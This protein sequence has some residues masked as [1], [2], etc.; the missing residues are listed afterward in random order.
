MI[1]RDDDGDAWLLISQVDHAM[2]AADLAAVW[3]NAEVA[4]LPLAD[5]LVPAIRDHDEGWRIWEEAPSVTQEGLPRQF[6]EMSSDAAEQIWTRSIETCGTGYGSFADALRRL[7][8]EGGEVAPDDASV[9]EAVL[10]Y[11]KTISTDR[12]AAQIV[13]EGELTADAVVASL[14]R[15]ERKNVIRRLPVVLGGPAYE[16]VVPSSGQSPLGGIWVSKHFCALAEGARESR[17]EDAAEVATIDRFLADQAERQSMWS[18][19]ASDF[20]GEELERVIDTGFRYVQF[21][22]RLSLWLCMA[23]RVEAWEAVLSSSFAL[24]LTPQDPRQIAV[25]PWPFDSDAVEL[26]VPALRVPV[27]KFADDDELRRVLVDAERTTLRWV[28]TP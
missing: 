2:L 19:A 13:G 12:L 5:W 6:T 27:R 21:F 25:A 8:A 14:S 4:K 20:A 1:R 3:G 11:R 22:D 17:K 23:P 7:R 16:I 9:L 15:L 18:E 10:K 28:L 26:A 24:T